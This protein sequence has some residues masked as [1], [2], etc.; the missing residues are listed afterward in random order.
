MSYF[1]NKSEKKA[2]TLIEALVDFAIVGMVMVA[3]F[4]AFSASFKSIEL[5]KAKIAA[6]ALANEKM[7]EIRNMPYDELA[8]QTG[9]IYPPGQIP[10]GQE[11]ARKGITFSV[12]IVIACVDDPFDG[13]GAADTALNSCDYKRAEIIVR[14]LGKSANLAKL[15]SFVAA[16]A[17]ETASSTGIIKLCVIDSNSNPVVDAVITITNTEVDPPVNISGVT[18][19]DGCISVPTLPPDSHNNYHLT[20]TKDGFS[21]DLT[22][23]R[24][25]QN[26]NAVIPDV[27]VLIQQVTFQTLVID[28]IAKMTI[29]V[30]DEAGSPVPNTV[31][32]V[33]GSKLRYFNPNCPKYTTDQTYAQTWCTVNPAVS[34]D[35][36]GVLVLNDL[37]FDDYTITVP[38]W[39]IA[40]T[41]PYQPIHLDAGADIGIS[42]TVTHS[43]SMPMITGIEPLQ[44]KRGEIVSV[45]ISGYN[46]TDTTTVEL[47]N[48]DGTRLAGTNI[49]VSKHA[50]I[51]T[52]DVDFDLNGNPKEFKD[53]VITNP[54]GEAVIQVNGFE[55]I[56]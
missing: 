10:D 23:P 7:E 35:A 28:Y 56:E 15:S 29:T 18:G 41:S 21:T 42:L 52:L 31:I 9:L 32:N 26:P 50:G 1:G 33:T 40:A 25:A 17:A 53:V 5:A 38:T 6:V 39:N 49:V 48:K 14:K 16:K 51:D 11:V 24:T 45:T 22:W 37:E 27:D 55:V 46:F 4:G 13:I 44:G 19:N 34:T 30:K 36:N 43:T 3:I 20:A 54:G 8:T 12:N 2:F 47:V